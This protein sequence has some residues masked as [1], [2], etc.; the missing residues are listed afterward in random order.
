M[1][2]VFSILALAPDAAQAQFDSAF[3]GTATDITGAVTPGAEVTISNEDPGVSRAVSTNASG[4]SR[5]AGLVPG[6]L[7][8]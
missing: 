5:M 7:P 2:L 8:A 6:K 3:G 4:Y 1:L